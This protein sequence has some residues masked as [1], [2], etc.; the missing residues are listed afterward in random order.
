MTEVFSRADHV[1]R[2]ASIKTAD[3]DL[4]R[5]ALKLAPVSYEYFGEENKAGD[6]G[7]R[8]SKNIKT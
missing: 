1:I 3:G 2:S 4:R 7:S 6:V 5:P 8:G